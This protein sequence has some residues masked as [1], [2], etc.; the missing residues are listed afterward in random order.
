MGV[1][2]ANFG[3]DYTVYRSMGMMTLVKQRC[4][5]FWTLHTCGAVSQAPFALWWTV[6]SVEERV[7][8]ELDAVSGDV[9]RLHSTPL[10]LA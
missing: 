6:G 5:L 2:L 4:P 9:A 8:A 10:A 7:H 3:N 1:G